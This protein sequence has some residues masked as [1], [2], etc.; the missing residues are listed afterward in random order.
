M[1]PISSC[2]RK[3][4]EQTRSQSQLVSRELWDSFW[5][6]QTHSSRAVC[7]RGKHEKDN[8]R[9]D[10]HQPAHNTH[11]PKP[12][13]DRQWDEMNL[14]TEF[15]SVIAICAAGAVMCMCLINVL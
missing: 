7:P 2:E 3:V 9:A 14:W 10:N 12:Q 11:L 1:N 13:R 8:L 15:L 6:S 5:L 4:E